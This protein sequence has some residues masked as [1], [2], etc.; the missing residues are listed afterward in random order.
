MSTVG[1]QHGGAFFGQPAKCEV[2]HTSFR[3][4]PLT[5]AW[6]NPSGARRG[7]MAPKP[8]PARLACVFGKESRILQPVSPVLVAFSAIL[9][10]SVVLLA[11]DSFIDTEALAFIYL[12][13]TIVMAMHY[14]KHC[15]RPED[16]KSVV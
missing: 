11:V 12:L 8:E 13:L 4:A 16:R 3:L 6:R 5:S 15:W 2:A 1:R 10:T 7:H 14:G 9:L